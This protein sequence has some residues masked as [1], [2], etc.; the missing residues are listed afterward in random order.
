MSLQ[1]QRWGAFGQSIGRWIGVPHDASLAAERRAVEDVIREGLT[2]RDQLDAAI[3][4]PTYPEPAS[5]GRPADEDYARV[6]RR[7]EAAYPALFQALER[8]PERP[9]PPVD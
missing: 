1:S 2:Y 3:G 4:A 8:G 5:T 9:P 6:G 7:R